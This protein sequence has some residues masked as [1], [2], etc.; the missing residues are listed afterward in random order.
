MPPLYRLLAAA[1]VLLALTANSA[2]GQ[3]SF[4][5]Q[6]AP[7]PSP[8]IS[9]DFNQFDGEAQ[10]LDIDGDQDRDVLF[11]DGTACGTRNMHL[12]D[13]NGNFSGIASPFFFTMHNIRFADVDGDNDWDVLTFDN[14]GSQNFSTQIFRQ[15][16]TAVFVPDSNQLPAVTG[17]G[18][19]GDIDNDGDPDLIITGDTSLTPLPGEKPITHLYKNDGTGYYQLHDDTTFVTLNKEDH[20]QFVDYDQDGDQDLLFTDYSP[21]RKSIHRFYFYENKGTGQFQLKKGLKFF[22]GL[23]SFHNKRLL[24]KDLNGDGSLEY[25][26]SGSIFTGS[27][28]LNGI[29]ITEYSNGTFT[30]EQKIDPSGVPSSPRYSRLFAIDWQGSGNLDILA[31]TG[32][33]TSVLLENNGSNN[34]TS[35]NIPFL[36]ILGKGSVDQLL[37]RDF[38]GD[39]HSDLM[40]IPGITYAIDTSGNQQFAEALRPYVKGMNNGTIIWEDINGDNWVDLVINGSA[41]NGG[42]GFTQLHFNQGGGIYSSAPDDILAPVAFGAMALSD[43]D[44]DGD[45]DL[46]VNGDQDQSLAEKLRTM[47]YKNNGTGGFS[48]YNDSTL[49]GFVRGNITLIDIN[50]DGADDVLLNGRDSLNKVSIQFY[51]NDGNGNYR[52]GGSRGLQAFANGKAVFSDIDGDNDEDLLVTGDSS[53]FNTPA[54][55]LYRNNGQ[56]NFTKVANTPFQYLSESD[57]VAVDVDGDNDEDIIITGR[58]A[59]RVEFTGIY[60]NDGSGTYTEDKRSTLSGAASGQLATADWNGDSIPDLVISGSGFTELYQN[61]GSGLFT[62]LNLAPGLPQLINSSA[63]TADANKDG[64]P[65]LLIAGLDMPNCRTE[66]RYFLN[67][68]QNFSLRENTAIH[69]LQIYPNPAQET[70]TIALPQ[71]HRT[72]KLQI[73]DSQG[74]VLEEKHYQNTRIIKMSQKYAPGLYIVNILINNDFQYQGRLMIP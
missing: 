67:T 57:A 43:I 40:K 34:F 33:P 10:S 3:V 17:T 53:G 56:G 4:Q 12:N 23:S 22:D 71:R 28:T 68:T 26:V 8:Q 52:P 46:I 47:V 14:G 49:P 74:R 18:A 55:W 24:V 2:K 25:V 27:Q 72:L 13:G 1:S 70:F 39:G 9:F 38:T 64:M 50:Q 59:N 30:P 65:D 29:F 16:G 32:F 62:K 11:Y 45:P 37:Y 42:N 60:L 41:T 44:N 51:L 66:T 31:P 48:L 7:P 69:P 21:R 6:V 35:V 20:I 63:V 15:N 58:K 36:P 54:T 19:F 5:E 61:D 73:V